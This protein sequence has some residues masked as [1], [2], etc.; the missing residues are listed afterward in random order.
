MGVE[1]FCKIVKFIG[2]LGPKKCV[3]PPEI[4]CTRSV[5]MPIMT[6][7]KEAVVAGGMVLAG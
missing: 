1:F 5:E 4:G 2:K 3:H 7:R 6:V